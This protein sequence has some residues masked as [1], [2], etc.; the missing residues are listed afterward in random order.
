MRTETIPLANKRF[1]CD[2]LDVAA[3][4]LDQALPMLAS[5]VVGVERSQRR[6]EA[7]DTRCIPRDKC[8]LNVDFA[9]YIEAPLVVQLR[10][11]H[12]G[13]SMTPAAQASHMCLSYV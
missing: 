8:S 9:T 7:I 3:R 12:L 1:V 4:K 5:A 2:F 13:L 6:R 10:G 11:V